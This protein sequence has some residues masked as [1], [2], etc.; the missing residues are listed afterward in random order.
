[1]PRLVDILKKQIALAG[2]CLTE[3]IES[4][5]GMSLYRVQCCTNVRDSVFKYEIQRD[6]I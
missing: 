3:D 2:Q 6:E 5:L 1:M 4:K